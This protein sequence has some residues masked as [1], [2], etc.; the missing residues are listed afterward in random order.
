MV[1]VQERYLLF[2]AFAY[3]EIFG[4]LA[5]SRD[6]VQTRELRLKSRSF[7]KKTAVLGFG[8]GRLLIRTLLVRLLRTGRLG[9]VGLGSR[10]PRSTFDQG[11]SVMMCN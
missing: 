8:K 3:R 2:C 7:P 10:T 4:K 1:A 5:T 6:G 9:S 11:P